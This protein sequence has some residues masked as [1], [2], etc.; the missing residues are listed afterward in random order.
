MKEYQ[1]Y[2]TEL[3]GIGRKEPTVEDVFEVVFKW[4]RGYGRDL[5][6]KKLMGKLGLDEMK[7][8]A[9]EGVIMQ[10]AQKVFEKYDDEITKSVDRPDFDKKIFVK[11]KPYKQAKVGGAS[12]GN[13]ADIL[14]DIGLTD[15]M[16]DKLEEEIKAMSY[17]KVQEIL[18]NR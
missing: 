6:T 14:Y 4:G 7:A 8:G 11:G 13:Y 3:F 1:K 15:E 18:S 12:S 17:E 5:I 16:R 9:I 10:S 2:L